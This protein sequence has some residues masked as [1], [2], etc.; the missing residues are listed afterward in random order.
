MAM[1]I[2]STHGSYAAQDAAKSSAAGSMRKKEAGQ[3][4]RTTWGSRAE[5]M[6][7][8]VDELAKLAPSVDVRV[9]NTF[10]SARS[11]KTLTLD[12]GILNKMRNDAQK[13]KD[14]KDMIKGVEFITKFIDGLYKSSGKTLLY[15]HSYIDGDG[16]YRCFSR[17]V[18]G[19]SIKM[20][21]KLRQARRKNSQKLTAKLR[22]KAGKQRAEL[23]ERTG[24][25]KDEREVKKTEKDGKRA[26]FGRVQEFLEEKMAD[27]KD[28]MVYLY[29]A[30]FRTLLETAKGN[31]DNAEPRG[32][33]G[34]GAVVDL[35]L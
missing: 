33:A 2:T 23:K 15:R 4:E 28:G 24:V 26:A 32:Q 35:Q 27:S 16:K 3:A 29:D 8:Y 12:P 30:D 1:D 34:A 17:V 10:S 13:E 21:S 19:R 11:G 6:A 25:K 9:G 18:D 5:T 31:G 14:M 22:E 7:D 20:S